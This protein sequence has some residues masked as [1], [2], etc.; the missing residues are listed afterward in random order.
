MLPRK[1]HRPPFSL[2]NYICDVG[3]NKIVESGKR[4]AIG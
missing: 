4:A 2:E 3:K 1:F